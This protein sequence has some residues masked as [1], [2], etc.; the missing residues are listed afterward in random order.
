M[1]GSGADEPFL[2]RW[3]RRKQQ[4]GTPGAA[5]L[6]PDDAPRDGAADEAGDAQGAEVERG[7][8]PLAP[9]VDALQQAR[10]AFADVDF[11]ALDFTS[12]YTRFMQPGVPDEIRNKALRKL[13]VSDPVLANMDGLHDYFGDYTDKAVASAPVSTLYRV[14]RGFLSDREVAEWEQLGKPEGG[15]VLLAG[16]RV[17]P[18]RAE[19]AAAL[20]EVHRRA[21]LALGAAGERAEDVE[22]GSAGRDAEHYA[23]AM[24]GDAAFEVVVSEAAGPGSEP[25]GG[26]IVAFLCRN[27]EALCALIVDPDFRRKGVGSAL[28]RRAE[29]R[30]LEAGHGRATAT[31][32]LP[33]LPFYLAQGYRKLEE[34]EQESHG[35]LML[36]A[37]K[38]EKALGTGAQSG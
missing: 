26:H 31:V 29:A 38:V 22:G 15:E 16:F 36:Q 7:S 21:S 1:S 37:V 28:L 14:G 11:D 20:A 25:T 18:G 30:L 12:D 8:A 27:G 35:A 6:R 32:S 10:A 19:D 23:Q 24:Q 33:A 9:E 13:W 2:Q 34:T 4:A 5:A 17:R 3:S